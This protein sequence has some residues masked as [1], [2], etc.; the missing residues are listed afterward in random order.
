MSGIEKINVS[1]LEPEWL[2]HVEFID[3]PG[4]NTKFTAHVEASK[5]Q[6]LMRMLLYMFCHGK[7]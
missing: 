7:A 2:R 5:K 3:T 4:R 6:L 1:L